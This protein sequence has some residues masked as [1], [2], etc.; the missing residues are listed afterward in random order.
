MTKMH[1]KVKLSEN[2]EIGFVVDID[3]DLYLI[4]LVYRDPNDKKI[5]DLNE[6]KKKALKL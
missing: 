6:K 4:Y 1:D 2:E 3:R 5:R